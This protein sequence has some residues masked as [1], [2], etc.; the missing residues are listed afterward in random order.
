MVQNLLLLVRFFPPNMARYRPRHCPQQQTQQP[1]CPSCGKRFNN[2]LRHLNHQQSKCAGWFNAALPHHGSLLHRHGH[3]TEDPVDFPILDDTSNTQQSLHFSILDDSS[4]AQQSLPPS[5]HQP[6][7]HCVE[8]S[9]AAKTY[10]RVKTFMDWFNDDRYSGF[11]TTNIYYP[12]VGKGEW[13]LGSFLLS[14]GLS[15][16][17]IDKFLQLKMVLFSIMSNASQFTDLNT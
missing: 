13:E 12:F 14:S 11:R 8:F 7:V 4:D 3:S 17:K 5:H 6:H 15:M 16:K 9:G 2:I 1:R 10:G